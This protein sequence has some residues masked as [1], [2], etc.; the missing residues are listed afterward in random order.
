MRAGSLADGD[1]VAADE[2]GVAVGIDVAVEDEDRDAGLDGVQD[3]AGET[4]QFLGRDQQG[5]D[6][7][8]DEVLDVGHLLLGAVLAVRHQELDILVL[9]GLG[10]DVLVELDPPGLD[11]G[12][13]REPDPIGLVLGRRRAERR[14]GG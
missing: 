11:R 1:V 10:A 13:L 14:R 12:H 3:H 9:L 5:I 2:L 8:A 4:G 7:L 6:L